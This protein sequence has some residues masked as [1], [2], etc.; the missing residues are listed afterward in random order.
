MLHYYLVLFLKDI[1]PNSKGFPGSASGKE[2]TNARDIRDAGSIPGSG[3]S[4]GGGH[5]NPLQ[6]SCLENAMDIGPWRA[7]VRSVPKTFTNCLPPRAR[8]TCINVY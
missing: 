6:Y 1:F 5:S 8:V 7:K 4:L 2:P 3:R